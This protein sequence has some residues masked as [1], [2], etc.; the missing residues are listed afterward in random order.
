VKMMIGDNDHDSSDDD[1]DDND[2]DNFDIHYEPT[3][4]RR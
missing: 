2:S 1:T 4:P 3:Y